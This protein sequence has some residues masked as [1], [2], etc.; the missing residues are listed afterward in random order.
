MKSILPFIVIF[1]LACA[2]PSGEEKYMGGGAL[3]P[4]PAGYR[5]FAL[6]IEARQAAFLAPKDRVDVYVGLVGGPAAAIIQ[7][8]LLLGASSVGNGIPSGIIFLG[9]NPNE[10]QYLALCS[11]ESPKGLWVVERSS[12]A[13]EMAP[14][15]NSGFGRL[16]R[17]GDRSPAPQPLNV[18]EAL[19]GPSGDS[20]EQA[21]ARSF[22]VPIPSWQADGLRAGDFVDLLSTRKI[23]SRPGW[24]QMVTVTLIQNASV[25][26]IAPVP[27]EDQRKAVFLN[28]SPLEVLKV[29]KVAAK[30]AHF[31]L[32]LR[33][34]GDS[35]THPMEF[36]SLRRLF[37]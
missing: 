2:P 35:E 28:L 26:G 29:V 37:P 17:D 32:T 13:P 21:R 11:Y 25:L 10:A 9:V 8:V 6:K 33:M 3:L 30:E 15:E 18:E 12:D 14:R 20:A 4:I 1:L 27:G 7:N 23:S 36:A 16:F 5:R 22:P 24:G 34:S 31:D 19:A